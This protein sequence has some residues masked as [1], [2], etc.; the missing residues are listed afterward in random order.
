M[1]IKRTQEEIDT[2]L[3]EAVEQEAQGKTKW[4]GMTYEQGVSAAIRWLLGETDDNP[5]ED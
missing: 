4:R 1:E 5:M 2:V 3:N